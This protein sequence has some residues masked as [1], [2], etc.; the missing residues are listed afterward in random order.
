MRKPFPFRTKLKILGPKS[1][2]KV[3]SK[4]VSNTKNPDQSLR[5][6][7]F[8]PTE[9][10]N[11]ALR[12][13]L[14][15]SNAG[16]GA[17]LLELSRETKELRQKL[18]DAIHS[19]RSAVQNALRTHREFQLA[20]TNKSPNVAIPWLDDK[21]FDMAKLLNSL[22]DR[23]KDKRKKLE[24]S[25]QMVTVIQKWPRPGTLPW[26][27]DAVNEFNRLECQIEAQKG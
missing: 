21:L 9:R 3:I 26:E 10:Y 14:N 8:Y 27:Q 15:E 22:L 4:K 23:L 1:P 24:E 11:K 5:L 6:F 16:A 2:S 20:M 18:M 17:Y 25:E 13:D 7:I 12:D 19:E